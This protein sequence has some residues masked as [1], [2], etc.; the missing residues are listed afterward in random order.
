MMILLMLLARCADVTLIGHDSTGR[1]LRE[2]R[3][4]NVVTVASIEIV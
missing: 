2:A 3:D 1:F 4:Q